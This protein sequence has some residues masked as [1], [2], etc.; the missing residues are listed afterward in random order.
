MEALA[1][2]SEVVSVSF[3]CCRAVPSGS[4]ARVSSRTSMC[5]GSFLSVAAWGEIFG[6]DEE[7]IGH[8]VCRMRRY[9]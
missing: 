2:V 8:F 1:S 4:L 7:S 9:Q 6:E 5:K 3:M